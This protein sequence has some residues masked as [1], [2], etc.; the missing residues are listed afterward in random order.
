VSAGA[1]HEPRSRTGDAVW[2]Q[3]AAGAA[4]VGAGEWRAV[5]QRATAAPAV[6]AYLRLAVPGGCMVALEASSFD[7]TT[8]LAGT[9]GVLQVCACMRAGARPRGVQAYACRWPCMLT[10][11]ALFTVSTC[12]WTRTWRCSP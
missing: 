4:R 2:P 9:L 5:W 11:G 10:D 7:V 1:A 8:M 12:R 6:A 3:E